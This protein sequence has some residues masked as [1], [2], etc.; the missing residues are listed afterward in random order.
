M[1]HSTRHSVDDGYRTR[2]ADPREVRERTRQCFHDVQHVKSQVSTLHEM[3]GVLLDHLGAWSVTDPGLSQNRHRLDRVLWT[4]AEASGGVLDCLTAPEGDLRIPITLMGDQLSNMEDVHDDLNPRFRPVV[5]MD[6]TPR[7]WVEAFALAVV[8]GRVWR[9]HLAVGVLLRQDYV[10]VLHHIARTT[11][12]PRADLAQ[13]DALSLYLTPKGHRDPLPEAALRRPTASERETAASA[14]D[15]AGELS[16]EQALLRVLLNDDQ[17]EF[18]DAVADHLD[19]YRQEMGAA[20]DPAPRTLLP[21]EVI[22]LVALAVQVHG[23]R[24]DPGSAYV[25]QV[26]VRAPD[27]APPVAA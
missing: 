16:G 26:W 13:M 2:I 6:L 22:A 4:A 18:E 9:R 17:A 27:G 10:P 11:P 12:L 14:L 8:S 23:W 7:L 25:P 20:R 19:R 24:V 3:S 15:A 5:D 1:E 21:V